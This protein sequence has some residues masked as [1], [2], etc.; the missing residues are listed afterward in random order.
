MVISGIGF[1]YTLVLLC[2]GSLDSQN[3][4][5]PANSTNVMYKDI[6]EERKSD[7]I[8]CAIC[9]EVF[10]EEDYCRV[11]PNCKHFFHQPCIDQWLLLHPRCPLC[12]AVT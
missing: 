5:I 8:E 2:K 11:L 4:N 7:E 3:V 12:N 6:N 1:V 10:K 9:L